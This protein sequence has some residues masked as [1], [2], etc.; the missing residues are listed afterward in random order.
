MQLLRLRYYQVSRDLGY[1]VPILAIVAS[2]AAYEL[3]SVSDL[4]SWC[5]AGVVAFI[6]YSYHSQRRD[7]GFVVRYFER[8]TLQMILNYQLT[9][10]P[11]T[12]ALLSRVRILP[13]ISLHIFLTLL[14]FLVWR[15]RPARISFLTRWIPAEHFEWIAGLRR[16]FVAL[17]VF[18]LLAVVL[19]PVKL[20]GIMALFAFN[21]IILGFYSVFEPR[22]M[23]NPEHLPVRRFLARKVNFVCAAIVILN[24]PLV[25]VNSFCHPEV[26]TMNAGF[27]AAFLLLGACGVYIKY[28]AYDP[29]GSIPISVDMLV[30]V[31]SVFIPYLLPLSVIIYFSVKKRAV[32][33]LLEY[34]DDHS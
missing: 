26:L 19:S 22:M 13:A 28:A 1:W 16:S 14:P 18:Y 27:F 29:S 3:S 20:F 12:V 23:L 21:F 15:S 31:L 2:Y 32:K 4:Y 8:G 9:A 17:I 5:L 34:S 7:V 30:L 6:F 10:L 25:A 24:L 11:V 33:N